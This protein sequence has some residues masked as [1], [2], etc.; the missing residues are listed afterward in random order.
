MGYVGASLRRKED[1]KLLRGE[2]RYA[3]DVRIA[4]L[5]QATIVRSPHAHARLRGVDARAALKLPGVVA[6]VAAADLPADL[7]PI[8]LRLTSYPG[9]TDC[10]QYPLARDKVRY[11]GDPVAIVVAED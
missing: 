3:A 6:V 4:G 8:P 1:A 7:Q 5:L 11:V 10:L 2:G 9:L